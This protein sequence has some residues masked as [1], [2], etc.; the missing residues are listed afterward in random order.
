MFTWSN[1]LH[2]DVFPGVRK[3]EAEVIAMVVKMFNGNEEACGTTT[4]GGTESILMACRAYR[5]WGKAVKGITKPEIVVPSSVHCAF[6]KACDYFGIKLVHVP[7]SKKTWSADIEAMRR[8]ITSNTVAL[9]GSAPSFP[10]GT[11]DDIQGLAALARRYNVGLHVD[12]CLGGFLVPF[13]AKAGYPLRPFDFRVP[14]VTSISCDTHKYGFAPKGSSVILYRNKELRSFQY[15]VAP[16]WPGG[17]YAS[18]TIAGSRPGALIA[19]CWATMMSVGEEGYVRATREVIANTRKIATGIKSIPGLKLLGEPLVSVVAFTSDHFDIYRLG[20]EMNHRGWNL[21]NLQYP[22]SIHLCLTPANMHRAD[23]F[24]ADL[25]SI[26]A[27]LMKNPAASKA[28]GAGAIYGMSQAVPDRS[29]IDQIARGYIDVLFE[30]TASSSAGS[31]SAEDSN[32]S[33]KE[34]NN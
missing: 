21:N 10:H 19:A 12:S 33:R 17:I 16:D 13:M 31:S 7:V 1:P 26:A 23:D 29:I 22:S 18:P 27:E 34:S 24:V 15:F 14:G 2:P 25:Q 11:M 9:V 32:T 4:S 30:S 6:D 20:E 8:A 28:Q 3:M 5:E